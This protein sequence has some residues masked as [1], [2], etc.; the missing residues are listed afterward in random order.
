MD[1]IDYSLLKTEDF[2][3]EQKT[4]DEIFKK[5]ASYIGNKSFDHDYVQEEILNLFNWM[6]KFYD[7]SINLFKGLGESYE[8]SKTFS[9]V[10]IKNYGMEM[11]KYLSDAIKYFCD[12][13]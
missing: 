11:P 10:L 6:N 1:K 8:F 5:I 7:C 13:K 4:R 2:L 9:D 12:N 3:K